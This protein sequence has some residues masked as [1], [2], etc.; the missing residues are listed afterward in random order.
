MWCGIRGGMKV[1]EG[2][3]ENS[4]GMEVSWGGVEYSGGMEVSS[5]EWSVARPPDQRPPRSPTQLGRPRHLPLPR[6]QIG[7]I[8]IIVD[9]GRGLMDDPCDVDASSYCATMRLCSPIRCKTDIA[10]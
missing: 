10:M 2:G 5:M 4:C 9:D 6:L 3:V 7:C 1:C 8:L